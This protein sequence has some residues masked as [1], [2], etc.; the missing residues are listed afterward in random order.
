MCNA[1][2]FHCCAYDGFSGCGCEWCPNAACHDDDEFD[3]GDGDAGFICE[4][5]DSADPAIRLQRAEDRLCECGAAGSG[6][7]HADWCKARKFDRIGPDVSA[8]DALE[9]V[10]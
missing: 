3:D 8:E 10:A 7:G 6:E 1:C 4:A 5:I 2:G 9:Y